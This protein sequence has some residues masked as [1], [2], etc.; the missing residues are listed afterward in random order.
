MLRKFPRVLDRKTELLQGAAQAAT[1]IKE[2]PSGGKDYSEIPEQVV[3]LDCLRDPS[4]SQEGQKLCCSTGSCRWKLWVQ[5]R[6]VSAFPA[7]QLCLHR[8]GSIAGL[9]YRLH[10]RRVCWC[11]NNN[12]NPSP[13][14]N[15]ISKEQETSR[16]IHISGNRNDECKSNW[17]ESLKLPF[18]SKSNYL[19]CQK[20][21]YI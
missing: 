18:K 1:E 8:T 11:N 20:G 21:T 12:L 13:R 2:I 17:S 19:N 4:D 7:P 3:R 10:M 6:E 14:N 15:C 9:A 5:L 16:V